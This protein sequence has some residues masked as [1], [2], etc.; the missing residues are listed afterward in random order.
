MKRLTKILCVAMITLA[1]AVTSL[2]AEPKEEKSN[3]GKSNAQGQVHKPEKK[4]PPRNIPKIKVKSAVK[5]H[6]IQREKNASQTKA[7]RPLAQRQLDRH[8][9]HTL[10]K[11]ERALIRDLNESLR[12]LNKARWSYHPRDDRGQGNMGKVNMLDP[13]GH[14][15]DSDRKELYG[16]RGRVIREIIPE[17]EPIPPEPE[18]VPPEP[19]PEPEPEPNPED[20]IPDFPF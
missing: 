20:P 16:N 17:P 12:K 7:L 19:E 9:E 1:F 11:N 14:D 4:T 18:P 6:A 2:H 3:N 10:R 8:M 15:K 13:F 5:N